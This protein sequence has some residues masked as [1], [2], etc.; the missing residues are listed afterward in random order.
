MLQI[1]KS[2]PVRP[3][4]DLKNFRGAERQQLRVSS[5]F[6]NVERSSVMVITK[7]NYRKGMTRTI[8]A[9]NSQTKSEFGTEGTDLDATQEREKQ[10]ST[11]N[12][13]NPFAN[14]LTLIQLS[15]S[16]L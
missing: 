9:I 4:I 1:D 8:E 7:Q 14:S 12:H 6:P 15:Q 5:C 2:K 11:E 10:V 16:L 3:Q 13:T